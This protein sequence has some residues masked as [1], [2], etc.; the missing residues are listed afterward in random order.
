MEQLVEIMR[1]EKDFLRSIRSEGREL[2]K[3]SEDEEQKTNSQGWP[4]GV[5]LTQRECA[6]RQH[7]EL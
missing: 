5:V 3:E 6:S 7:R 4:P 2:E 1:R